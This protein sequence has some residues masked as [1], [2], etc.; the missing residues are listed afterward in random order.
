[1]ESRTTVLERFNWQHEAEK[2]ASDF[3][4]VDVLIIQSLQG[5]PKIEKENI[6]WRQ[7]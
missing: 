4:G 6:L 1:M 5:Y 2:L 7:K 3:K